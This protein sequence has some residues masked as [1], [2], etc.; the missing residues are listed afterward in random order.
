MVNT[1][2]WKKFKHEADAFAAT[3]VAVSKT[4]P[5]EDIQA[6]YALGQRDFGENYVQELVEKAT[7]LPA[8][9]RWHFI[10][11]LQ[12]NKVKLLAPFVSMIHSVDSFRLLTE[13]NKAAVAAGRTIDVLLQMHLAE[14][15]ETKFGLTGD[16]LELFLE[17]YGFGRD[18]F[19]N[20]RIR[21][22][23]GMASN[24]DFIPQVHKEFLYIKSVFDN[25]RQSYFGG[26]R[27]FDTLSIGMSGDYQLALDT[28]STMIR[29]GSALFGPREP[30]KKP[31]TV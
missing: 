22:L 19:T 11:H 6:L 24:T 2:A 26:Q 8:D 9:I 12:T 14:D 20:V 27:F 28:G 21:G 15:E 23:M 17:D 13:I 4:K 29:I 10:G 7:Q 3:L 25:L 31:G 30:R 5:S 1:D 16:E 18:T